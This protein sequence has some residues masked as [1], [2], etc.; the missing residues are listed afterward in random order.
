MLLRE[1]NVRSI[2]E[3]FFSQKPCIPYIQGKGYAIVHEESAEGIRQTLP[4][5]I[6]CLAICSV[7]EVREGRGD[8]S[9]LSGT[10]VETQR[11]VE[12][13]S[14]SMA[15]VTKEEGMVVGTV[16]AE[17]KVYKNQVL[18]GWIDFFTGQPCPC[19]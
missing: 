16:D 8:G 6:S 17:G 5:W 9:C 15:A 12:N 11:I 7:G 2:I 10:S 3:T 18:I 14:D 4:C 1:K 19:W 13:W